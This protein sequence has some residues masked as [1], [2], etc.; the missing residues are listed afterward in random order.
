MMSMFGILDKSYVAY[1]KRFARK[2]VEWK[3]SI[4]NFDNSDD[5][6]YCFVPTFVLKNK[7]L[8]EG[9][10]PQ[11]GKVVVYTLYYSDIIVPDAVRTRDNL[12][13]I[14]FDAMT[15]VLKDMNSYQINLV[16][17]SLGNVE[18]MRVGANLPGGR[19]RNL[20]SLVGG[21]KLGFSSWNSIATQHIARNSGCASVLEYEGILREFSP[22]H[23]VSNIN[24]EKVFARFGKEDLMIRYNPHG[25]ELEGALRNMNS[26]EKD[27]KVYHFMDHC[28]SI[29]LS[30]M[31]G[32]HDRIK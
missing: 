3:P 2:K 21:A 5:A 11:K 13:E 32:I 20:V 12:R 27:I 23:Y 9:I 16:G 28:S 19:V 30:S 15:R 4:F 24:T 7:N 6:W 31:A 26:H 14:Y 18:A 17:I 22:I 10:L 25:K 29:I 8:R 1:K